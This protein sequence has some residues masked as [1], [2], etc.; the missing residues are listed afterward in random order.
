M[1]ELLGS[2]HSDS[3]RNDPKHLGFV[4]A[5]YTFVAKMLKATGA[6]NVLE[7]GCGDCTGAHIV[8]HTV[9]RWTGI[10][11]EVIGDAA[12]W[13]ILDGPYRRHEYDAIYALD[14]LEHI[15]PEDED[16]ALAN[17]CASLEKHGTV[18]LGTPSKE[19]QPW[20]SELSRRFHINCKTEEELREL[21]RR[22]F[23]NVYLFGMNDST[24][25][26]GFGPMCHYRL[27][28]CT[29]AIRA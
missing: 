16:L 11:K 21:L 4:F 27:A 28:I 12:S 9:P 1:L 25:H 13:D 24:L 23:H 14:V 15:Q 29:G 17:I 3:W 5:R 20:A 22:H 18:I 8:R 2:V 26:T 10:D 6:R 7:V 19:S